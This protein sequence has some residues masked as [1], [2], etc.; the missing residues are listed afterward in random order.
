MSRR[1]KNPA[2]FLPIGIGMGIAMGV[3]IGTAMDNLA[4]GLA[5]GVA[6]GCGFGGLMTIAAQ[7][8]ADERGDGGTIPPGNSDSDRPDHGGDQ[9]ADGG[10]DGGDGGGD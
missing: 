5:L 8:K 1:A 7:R 9:G 2:A 4:L 3:G 10:D 6:F